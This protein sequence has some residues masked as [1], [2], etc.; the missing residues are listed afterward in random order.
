MY[1]LFNWET[2][3]LALKYHLIYVSVVQLRNKI[4]CFKAL[5]NNNNRALKAFRETAHTGICR[6]HFVGCGAKDSKED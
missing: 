5:M 6:V 2:R 1:P 3:S 4:A